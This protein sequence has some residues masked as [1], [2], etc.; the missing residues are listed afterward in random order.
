[1]FAALLCFCIIVVMTLCGV[2][3]SS[4]CMRVICVSSLCVCKRFVSVARCMPVMLSVSLWLARCCSLRSRFVQLHV[5]FEVYCASGS[6]IGALC[7][8]FILSYL[9]PCASGVSQ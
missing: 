5:S 6:D 3:F 7:I 8:M 4:D 1:M 2:C 9:Y